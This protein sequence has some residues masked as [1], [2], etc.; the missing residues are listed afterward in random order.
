MVREGRARIRIA[1]LANVQPVTSEESPDTEAER[2]A[3]SQRDWRLLAL[4][5]IAFGIGFGIN[6]GTV[7]S[8]AAGE[9]RLDRSHLA[10]LESFREIPGLLT[11]GMI[12]ILAVFPEARLAALA[13]AFV[14]LG[15]GATGQAGSFWPLVL[16]NIVWSIGLHIWLTVQ[17][18]LTLSLSQ[19]GRHGFGLGLMNRYQAFA[20]IGGLIFVRLLAPGL[21]YG[22]TFLCA[23]LACA[24]G[25]LF[26]RQIPHWRGGGI[27]MRLL[28]RKEYWRYYA[29]MLLDGGRRQVVQTF[30]LLILVREFGVPLTVVATLLIV[31]NALTM[32]AAPLVGR[33][34]DT[35]GERKVLTIYYAL[36]AVVFFCYTQIGAVSGAMG[37]RPEWL[38]YV[39][40]GVDN[41]LFTASVGIQTYIRHTAPAEELSPSLAMG[42]TWNHIAAV[43]V[44]ILAGLIWE[45]FGYERIFAC[46]IG[47][48]LVSTAMCLTLPRGHAKNHRDAPPRASR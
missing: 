18:A 19:E 1:L 41:L 47:L 14:G 12:G 8:F 32:V 29:L 48:A 11:A 35:Y 23:G 30:G 43:S 20:I 34:T 38:F 7:P 33:W 42:L 36:V 22:W 40:F 9:L 39:V 45:R 44:P 10:Q 21:G 6:T 3:L 26:V 16:C 17:P 2:Q 27:R 31:N 25:A 5:T 37:W 13:L 46:G 24:S 4:A 15:I 28:F